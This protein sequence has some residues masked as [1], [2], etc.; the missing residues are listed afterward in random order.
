M[1]SKLTFCGGVGAVTGANFLF[2]VETGAKT[3][4]ILV[5]CGLLQG[6]Q[7]ADNFNRAKFPYDPAS[8]DILFITHAHADHIGRVPKLVKD[9]FK[10]VIYSTPATRDLSVVMLQDACALAEHDAA[11]K[12]VLPMFEKK[13]VEAALALWETIPFYQ[14]K[15]LGNGLSVVLKNSGHILGSA[16][17]ELMRGGKK[18][19]FTGDLGNS[20]SL[21]LPDTDAV[22]DADYMVMESVYGDRNHERKE[23]R[24]AKLRNIVR[25][26]I[27]GK[28]TLVIPVFSLERTQ[29]MLYELNDLV[30][31]K[32]IEP[33]PVF[34]DSP[35][36]I[37]VTEVYRKWSSEFKTEAQQRIKAGDDIFDFSKL[38]LTA[39]R[40]QS[41][42]ISS[43]PNPKI[44]M[45][46]SGMSSGGRIVYH[47]LRYLPD[48]TA[49][50][51]FVGYQSVGTLG[52][53][54][55]DGA[56]EV[57][58]GGEKI[59]VRSEIATID[60]YSSHKDSDHLVEFVAGAAKRVQ[61]VFVAMG[62][63]K[64]AL[65][66]VQRLRDY[67]GVNA[68]YPELNTSAELEF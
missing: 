49:I 55:Q 2:E 1:T 38:K 65:F 25:R 59:A 52:R 33:L 12:G 61:K 42:L 54:I 40:E 44:I 29:D 3:M 41:S 6:V 53:Q 46:G 7:H 63:P 11:V 34:I 15:D 30:E 13:D 60:G 16:M 48:P 24:K 17:V 58:I 32:L 66:L 10:G 43:T 19:V 28:K 57:T 21:F 51:C 20:P 37:K 9:G 31:G 5:D 45:A 56:K 8:I 36:G 50:V 27:A 22:T 39:R 67:L 68:V 35:L 23:E 18:T 47:E 14:H 64:S 4:K 26:A 62:E